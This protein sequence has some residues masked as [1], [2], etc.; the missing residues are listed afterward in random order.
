[1]YARCGGPH[2]SRHGLAFEQAVDHEAVFASHALEAEAAPLRP[3]GDRAQVAINPLFGEQA[4]DGPEHLADQSTRVRAHRTVGA[5]RK[6][7][8]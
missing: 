1:M 7:K 6:N 8:R 2:S 4:F 3:F 5:M